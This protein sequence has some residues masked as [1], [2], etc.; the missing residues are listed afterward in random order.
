MKK[1]LLGAAGIAAMG[2]SAFAADLPART[3]APPA[4]APAMVAPIYDWSGFYIGLNGG[5][6]WNRSCWTNT[7]LFG[8]ATVPSAPEGCLTGSG[9]TAGGQ[10]GYRWQSDNWVFGV[11]AQGNWAD[12]NGTAASLAFPLVTNQM[13]VDAFGLFTGQVG[14]A[15]NNALFYLKGGAALTDNKYAGIVTA[16]GLQLGTAND[17]RWGG[18]VGVGIEYGFAPNWSA[19][20]EYDH[21]FMSTQNIGFTGVA[22]GNLG[23]GT[24]NDSIDQNIDMVTARVNYRFGGPVVAR[25]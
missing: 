12:F 23:I 17:T 5:G 8:V 4:K 19:A 7:A 22:P 1:A 18:T 6:G 11:E 13:K 25:Y 20:I 24:R 15:W 3:Y 9:G 14:Y 10:A 2:T 16:S 21:L